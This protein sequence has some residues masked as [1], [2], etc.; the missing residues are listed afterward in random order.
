M[1]A[2]SYTSAGIKGTEVSLDQS[3]FGVKANQQLILEAYRTYL[4]N[5]RTN[6]AATLTRGLV[7]GGGKKPWRQKGTGRARSGSSR[8]PIWRGGGITFGPTGVENYKRTMPKNMARA[9]IMQALSTKANAGAVV[10]IEDFKSTD[11]KVA[12]TISFLN[13]IGAEGNI[14]IVV[15][16]NNEM[17]KRATRNIAGVELVC[18]RNLNVFQTVNADVILITKKALNTLVE[19]FCTVKIGANK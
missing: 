14:V 1:K 11:G 3:I 17:Q 6:N 8:N 7:S 4:A 9:A 18:A 5:Q 2:L 19:R 16:T 13:K 10:V 12:Q 15:D